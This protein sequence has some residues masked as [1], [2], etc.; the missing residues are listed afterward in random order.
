[1]NYN[2]VTLVGRLTS[3]PVLSKSSSG[4]EYCRGTVAINRPTSSTSQQNIV[5]FIPFVAWRQNAVFLANNLVKGSLILIEGSIQTG[6]FNN[7]QT[8]QLVRTTDI[9]VDRLIPLQS[10]EETLSR[11]QANLNKTS[12]GA[13][14]NNNL[15]TPNRVPQFS[16]LNSYAQPANSTQSQP[17]SAITPTNI[18]NNS[19]S[20]STNSSLDGFSFDNKPKHELNTIFAET[21]DISDG[22]DDDLE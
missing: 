9:S 11:R 18:F 5:D 22:F 14:S 13:F 12:A 3:D 19:Q 16:N 10:R 1:M 15:N 8:N 4:V 17:N 6:N 21:S 7:T 20:S 2:K